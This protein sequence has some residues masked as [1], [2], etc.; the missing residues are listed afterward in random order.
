[1]AIDRFRKDFPEIE[2]EILPMTSQMQLEWLRDGR[3]DAGFL[4]HRRADDAIF[5]HVHI[6]VDRFRL[7]LPRHHPLAKRRKL[8][9]RDL[10]DEK[11]VCFRRANVPHFY[12]Q[13]LNAC[14]KGGLIPNVIQEVDNQPTVL[15]LISV[16]MGLAFVTVPNPSILPKGVV[17]HEVDDFQMD[18]TLELV[19]VTGN[20]SPSLM[21]VVETVSGLMMQA[22]K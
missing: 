10:K 19:W 4:Y 6:K 16:G 14:A 12:E 8:K 5:S 21:R 13:L 9:L 7:A 11:F 22:R 15:D 17:L 3:I 20:K 2:L 18:N 1:M